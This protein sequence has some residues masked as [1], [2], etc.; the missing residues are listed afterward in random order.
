MLQGPH[1]LYQESWP[2]TAIWRGTYPRL[3]AESCVTPP[4][5]S[6]A[7][8]GAPTSPFSHRARNN[9]IPQLWLRETEKNCML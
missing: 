5:G 7:Q 2:G 1:F 6:V 9:E 8:C 3:E 4:W